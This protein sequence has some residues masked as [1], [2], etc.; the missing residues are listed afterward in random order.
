VRSEIS[1]WIDAPPET[2]FPLAAN[3]PRWPEWLP[4]Y[5]YVRI[6]SQADGETLA[7]MSARRGMIPVFW[8]AIQTPDA[9]ARR[10]HFR[11]VRGITSGMEVV[12]TL[13]AE[14]GGTRARIVH[15]LELRWPLVGPWFAE[16]VIAH[17]FIEP[18][19]RRTLARFKTLA[20]AS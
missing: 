16:H 4:H 19:A 20:E 2:V 18:I 12:W 5:R 15:D 1:T 11:H 7:A 6:L 10:I 13:E 3:L 14:R 17:G 8:H 9:A